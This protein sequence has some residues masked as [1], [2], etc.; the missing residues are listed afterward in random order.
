MFGYLGAIVILVSLPSFVFGQK[1]PE[2]YALLVGVTDYPR[3]AY[4]VEVPG[5]GRYCIGDGA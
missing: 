3:P 4:W 1:V 2:K 5:D